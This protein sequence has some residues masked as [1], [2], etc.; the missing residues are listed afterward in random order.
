ME[1]LG[2]WG[3]LA[4][5]KLPNLSGIDHGVNHDRHIPWFKPKTQKNKRL[6]QSQQTCNSIGKERNNGTYSEDAKNGNPEA[7]CQ[8]KP[9]VLLLRA[10]G[11]GRPVGMKTCLGHIFH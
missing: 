5:T 10:L 11:R 9:N 3:G 8:H 4:R 2:T 6:L 1:P 7:R